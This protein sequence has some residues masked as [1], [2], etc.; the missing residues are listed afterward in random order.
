MYLYIEKELI[1][2]VSDLSD[3]ISVELTLLNSLKC[4][5]AVML[6]LFHFGKQ[7]HPVPPGIVIEIYAYLELIKSLRDSLRK[8]K[9]KKDL[10]R[11][12]YTDSS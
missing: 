7:I 9:I 3:H 2:A 1:P 6:A 4:S 11:E 10:E 8:R 12:L 5:T